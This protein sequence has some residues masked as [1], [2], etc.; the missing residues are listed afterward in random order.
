MTFVLVAA[1]AVLILALSQWLAPLP[2]HKT[3][4]PQLVLPGNGTEQ[5][6]V[7]SADGQ[8]ITL[9]KLEM[10]M[11]ELAEVLTD[12]DIVH[13][14]R[15]MSYMRLYGLTEPRTHTIYINSSVSRPLQIETVLHEA[16]HVVYDRH[17]YNTS[18]EPWESMIEARA[19]AT[20][21]QLYGASAPKEEHK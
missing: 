2:Y 1:I 17:G 5:T 15:L 7:I 3:F 20:Y 21:Q 12:Y 9:P 10:G 13:E 11:A 18:E 19:Q 14:G 16:W 4:Q 6:V 8:E